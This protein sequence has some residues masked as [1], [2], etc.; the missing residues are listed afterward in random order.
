MVISIKTII[1]TNIRIMKPKPFKKKE[2]KKKA[3]IEFKQ[4]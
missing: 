2:R 4:K 3:A 1:T